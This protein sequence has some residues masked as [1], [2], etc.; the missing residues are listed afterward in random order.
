MELLFKFLSSTL[1]HIWWLMPFLFVF[2]L[3]AAIREIVQGGSRDV[4]FG[5]AAAVSLL[6]LFA[7]FYLQYYPLY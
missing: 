2:F 5:F 3:L 6:I 1:A 7:A 4:Q